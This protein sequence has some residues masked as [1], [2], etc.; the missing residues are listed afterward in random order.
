MLVVTSTETTRVTRHINHSNPVP[1]NLVDWNYSL[2]FNP[3]TFLFSLF[4]IE[5]KKLSCVTKQKVFCP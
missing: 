5:N 3:G 1:S 2:T 4:V